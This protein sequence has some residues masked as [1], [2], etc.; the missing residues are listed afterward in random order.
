[1]PEGLVALLDFA[2]EV[3]RIQR[4]LPLAVLCELQQH[5]THHGPQGVWRSHDQLLLHALL[6]GRR[7]R[8]CLPARACGVRSG[9]PSSA[10][11]HRALACSTDAMKQVLPKFTRP[12]I[13]TAS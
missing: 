9:A 5:R 1:M 3:R 12:G 8:K 4:R 6:N 2:H 10:P 11:Q 7:A 13:C